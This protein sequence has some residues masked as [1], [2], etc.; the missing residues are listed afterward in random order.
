M[1]DF[2]SGYSIQSWLE[3]APQGYLMK[4]EYGHEQGEREGT[5]HGDALPSCGASPRQAST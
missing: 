4:T 1:T 3:S 2:L 5:P